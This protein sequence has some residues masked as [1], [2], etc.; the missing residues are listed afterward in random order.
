MNGDGQ[1]ATLVNGFTYIQITFQISSIIPNFGPTIGGTQVTITGSGFMPITQY[2]ADLDPTFDPGA[3]ADW[4]ITAMALQP[5]NRILIGGFFSTYDNVPRSR[6]ARL[7]PDGSLDTTFNPGSGANDSIGTI[8]LQPDGR[9]IIGGNFTEY[10]GVP[11]NRIARLNPDGSLDTTFNPG[12]GANEIVYITALQPDGRILVGG[13]FTEINGITRNRI[14]RLNPD[15]SLD[16][17]FNPG[18]GADSWIETIAIQQD[19][20]ILIGGEFWRYDNVD[21][22][23]IARLNPDGSLDTSFDIG[24]GASATVQNIKVQA[25]GKIVIVGN[26]TTFNDIPRSRVARLN[27][28]GSVDMSFNPGAGANGWVETTAI[29]ND[30]KIIIVGGFTTY[31]NVPRVRI[32]RINSDGSLDTT[33]DQQDSA[34]EYIFNVLIQPD[35]KILIAGFFTEYRG[36]S[37]NRIARIGQVI[38]TLPPIVTIDG[39]LCTN[40]VL[41]SDTELTCITPPGTIGPK[42][43]VILNGNGFNGI[44]PGGFTYYEIVMLCQTPR[45]V[46]ETTTCELSSNI[47]FNNFSEPIEVRVLSA[48]GSMTCSLPPN[49]NTMTCADVPLPGQIGAYQSQFR[50][51]SSNQWFDGNIVNVIANIITEGLTLYYDAGHPGS[52]SGSGQDVFDLS[53]ANRHGFL[54]SNNTP[55]ASDPTWVN[56]QYKSFAFD[57]VDDFINTTLPSN[58][59]SSFSLEVWFRRSNNQSVTNQ[60]LITIH[61][62]DQGKISLGIEGQTVQGLVVDGSGGSSNFNSQFIPNT[63]WQMATL[64]YDASTSQLRIYLNGVLHTTQ[65]VSLPNGVS[66]T[67]KIGTYLNNLGVFSGNIAVVRAYNIIFNQ[68]QIIQNFDQDKV[69]FGFVNS[70][71]LVDGLP[72]TT[73]LG[74]FTVPETD[75]TLIVNIGNINF[76]DRR[77]VF[78]PWTATIRISNLTSGSNLI[79]AENWSIIT[80]NSTQTIVTGSGLYNQIASGGQFAGHNQPRLLFENLDLNGG[81]EFV[82]NFDLSMLLPAYTRAGEYTGVVTIDIV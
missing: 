45:R 57:G 64:T 5:D 33:F 31:D 53:G 71:V 43:V 13:N 30:G 11:I 21:R 8:T 35:N 73:N 40:V 52:Y 25:D 55:E 47:P 60:N 28:D 78:A 56:D 61:H 39:N 44:L 16:T 82:I 37:R 54:G 49:G 81:G 34:N 10:N 72:A 14:A 38:N 18:Y 17:S 1:T 4:W 77:Q 69:R 46:G 75:Q 15:G 22:N 58:F 59:S 66:E 7:N 70:S 48:T 3:G 12:W 32:A 65:T 76:F 68:A 62:P 19:G 29:Q 51:V 9:I 42:D 63:E 41:V 80:Q 24:T 50:F 74:T 26:F 67:V 6:I 20:R 23:F 79:A 36:V 27:P 2:N